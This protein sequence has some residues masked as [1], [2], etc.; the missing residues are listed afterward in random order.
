MLVPVVALTVLGYT[1][2]G[3]PLLIGTLAKL[4]PIETSPDDSYT[5]MVSALIPAYNCEG[6]LDAKIDSLL[7][8]DYP[9]DKFEI[10]ILSDGSTDGTDELLKRRAA[11]DP[12]VVPMRS[13]VRS[14]KPT[15]LNVMREKARGEV[16]LLTDARQPLEPQSLRAL[17]RHFADPTVGCVSGNLVLDGDAGSGVYWRYE[18]WIREQ[19]A[20]FRS[21]VGVTGPIYAIRKADLREVPVDIV[22]DDVW[23]PMRLRLEGKKVLFEKAAVAHDAAFDDDREF[24]RKARTLAGN[25]QVFS[26]MPELLSP[27]TNPSFLETFS[28]KLLRLAG[29]WVLGALAG[30]SLTEALRPAKGLGA[31]G[32][33]AARGLVAGQ[34]VFYAAALAGPK[35]G[36]LPGV[37]RTFVMMN[38][39]AVVGLYRHMKGAQKITW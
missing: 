3:Y 35:A 39:A 6:Y 10:L 19:E 31:V 23:T 27:F 12:R 32:V 2:V 11:A 13:E 4:S 5:P 9:K 8:L 34:A 29:P 21:M 24:G 7:A 38:A 18:S 26:R 22:L 33:W 28:H 36:K 30:S 16:L 20:A 15:A 25:Y 1:Y 17:V 14:G 37:A